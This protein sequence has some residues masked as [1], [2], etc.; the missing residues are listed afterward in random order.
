MPVNIE[1]ASPNLNSKLINTNLIKPRL[2]NNNNINNN[3][4]NEKKFLSEFLRLKVE[5]NQ[6]FKVREFE[7]ANQ[8]FKQLNNL[9]S[10]NKKQISNEIITK[11][12]LIEYLQ[13][14]IQCCLLTNDWK[15]SLEACTKLLELDPNN[16]KAFHQRATSYKHLKDYDESI[17]DLERLIELDPKNKSAKSELKNIKN[18]IYNNNN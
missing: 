12:Q 13:I 15:T 5:G 9:I 2:E 7:K 3:N 1:Q 17:L 14:Q 8:K 10:S 11:D 18:L 6:L 16:L 4:N